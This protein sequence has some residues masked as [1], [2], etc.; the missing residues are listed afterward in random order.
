MF[1]VF[2]G[3]GE[4]G[5]EVGVGTGVDCVVEGGGEDVVEGCG[6]GAGGE[7]CGGLRGGGGAAGVGSGGHW[8]WREWLYS[9]RSD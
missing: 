6:A 9:V 5:G 2:R 1:G 3:R 7:G 4:A 8:V